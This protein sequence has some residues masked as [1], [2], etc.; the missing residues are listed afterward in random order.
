MA[1]ATEHD[2]TAEDDMADRS[3]RAAPIGRRRLTVHA[4]RPRAAEASVLS[5]VRIVISFMYVCH[6]AQ[7]TFGWFGGLAGQGAAVP[8]GAWPGWWAGLIELVGGALILLG[9]LTRPAAVLCSGEMA[10]AYFTV[11]QRLAPLPLQ[12]HGELAA[13]FCWIFL[14]IAALGAGPLSFD[15]LLDR[16]GNG[17]ADARAHR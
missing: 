1:S 7:K 4:V 16:P 6:A 13:L 14:L 8:V 2:P 11:H 5:A 12:N 9:L 10:F 15:A 17:D 3:D